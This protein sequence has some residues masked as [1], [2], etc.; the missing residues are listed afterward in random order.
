MLSTVY[1][2]VSSY[3]VVVRVIDSYCFCR[4]ARLVMKKQI[5]KKTIIRDGKEETIVTEDTQ[6]EQDDE[7]PDE[8]KE[9]MQTIVDQFITNTQQMGTDDQ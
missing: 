3:I 7:G 8:L 4:V 9:S 1:C 6:I 5:H 2:V